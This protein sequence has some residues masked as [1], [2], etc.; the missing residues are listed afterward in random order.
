MFGLE[1]NTLAFV[2]LVSLAA[3]AVVY[4]LLF[5]RVSNEK[6]QEKRVGRIKSRHSTNEGRAKAHAKIVDA[7]KRRQSVQSTLKELEERN[8]KKNPNRVG[9]KETIRQA[10]LSLSMRVFIV[11][12]LLTG[13]LLLAFT[14]LVSGKLLVAGAAGVV[15]GLGL[16]RWVIGYLKKRRMGKFTEEFPNAVD[17]IVRGVKAGLPLN[18]CLGIVAA[19]SKEPV[20]TEFKKIIET[21]N[22]GVPMTEA[23]QKL[24]KNVPLTEAN[25][26]G[27]VIAIQQGAGGNLSEALGNLS[28]VLRDRKKIKNKIKAMSAEAKAS[29]MIIG[30]LPVIV[31]VLVYLT[32]PSYI[33]TLFT[34]PTGH[35]ILMCSAVWMFIG[36]MVMRAMIN[37][38]F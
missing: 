32:T 35:I 11:I 15:G 14:F 9:I 13:F 4:T 22:M 3:C 38:D 8:K 16:P 17:V 1:L 18:D 37:F 34:H 31:A 2:G 21:Q 30:A 26:F 33:M 24:F 19:E 27:I 36:C 25:F 12:S 7:S 29:A 20:C 23:I 5:D 6:T 28:K 10:G